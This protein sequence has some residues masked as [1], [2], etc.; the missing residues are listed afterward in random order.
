MKTVDMFNDRTVFSFEV[1]PPKKT[2]G[3]ETIYKSLEEMKQLKPDFISVTFGAGGSEN[4]TAT[5]DIAERIKKICNVEPVV[6]LPCLNLT[7][8]E[9]INIL[10]NFRNA[11]IEN[12][13]ALRGD[14]VEGKDPCEDFEHASDLISFIKDFNE[15]TGS[16]FNILAASYPELHPESENVYSDIDSLKIKE[17]SGAN[18]FVSQLFLDNDVF[19]RF[20]ERVRLAGIKSPMEAGIMPVTNKKQIERMI[21]LCGATLPVKFQRILNRYENSQEALMDAGI[22]YAIDQIADLVTQGVQGIHLYTMNNSKTASRINEAIRSLF[23]EVSFH[24]Q[25]SPVLAL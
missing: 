4:C 12:I 24:N 13:L 19:Y 20:Y 11:G 7:K 5:L 14:K 25:K 16:D 23:K 10:Q 8:S 18:H 1:F 9:A 22:A 15:S 17:A 3:I 6:H 2:M 21:K